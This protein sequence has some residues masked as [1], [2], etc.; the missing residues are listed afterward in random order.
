MRRAQSLVFMKCSN[1][2]CFLCV[3]IYVCAGEQHGLYVKYI[4]FEENKERG[5]SRQPSKLNNCKFKE[6]LCLPSP[7]V[8]IYCFPRCHRRFEERH[9]VFYSTT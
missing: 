6:A 4:C 7:T 1:E 2:F 8:F 9:M 3:C 5:I